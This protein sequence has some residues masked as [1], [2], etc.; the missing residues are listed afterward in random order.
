MY[1]KIKA[2]RIEKFEQLANKHFSGKISLHLDQGKRVNE[3][4][5]EIE[6][7]QPDL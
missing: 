7:Y 1:K 3:I 6:S 5:M 2:E 4:V